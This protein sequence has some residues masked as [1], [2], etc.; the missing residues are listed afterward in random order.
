MSDMTRMADND[1]FAR[2]VGVE[3]LE[4]SPGRAK[5]RLTI[6]DHHLNGAGMV[7]GGAIFTLADLVFAAACNSHGTLAVA[8]NAHIAYLKAAAGGT[9]TAQAEEVSLNPRLATYAIAVRDDAGDL[10]ATFQGMC[11]RKKEKVPG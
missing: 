1:R 11:Y 5:A 7:H 4:I 6:A 2:H 3:L 8:I 9:L 10:V